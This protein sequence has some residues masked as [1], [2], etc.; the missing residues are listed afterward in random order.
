MNKSIIILL[1][2]LVVLL[3]F[4]SSNLINNANAIASEDEYY[5]EQYDRYANDEYKSDRSSYGNS[6]YD[7]E[8]PSYKPDYKQDDRSYGYEDNKYKSKDKERNIVSISNINCNTVNYNFDNVAIGNF[9]NGN[10]GIGGSVANDGNNGALNANANGNVA[11]YSDGYQKGKD[12]TC[13]SNI[14]N[15]N[16][17]IQTGNGGN[18]TNGNVTELNTTLSVTKIVTCTPNDI[19]QGAAELCELVLSN[20]P[21]S[22]FNI[23][24][25]GNN[26]NPSEFAGSNDPVVVNLGAG[27]YEVSEVL[28]LIPPPP[29]GTIS[30]N[31]S[32]DGDCTAT[33]PFS[34]E[35]TGTIETGESQTCF[36]INDY[37]TATL[38]GGGLTASNINTATSSSNINTGGV[39]SSFSQ[40]T[41]AQETGDLTAMEKI[42]KLKTQWLNQLS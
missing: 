25:T 8:Y 37:R 23:T 26:P 13:I 2:L 36:I 6:N 10:S 16:T 32:F 30:R 12:I 33:D 4:G 24:V 14:N 19:S 21:P 27:I 18:A 42:T 11:G 20:N 1:G 31:T 39:V 3:P 28:P 29:V 38:P 7:R 40:P 34:T 17:N 35:A 41:I 22:S 9:S 5:T 15:N